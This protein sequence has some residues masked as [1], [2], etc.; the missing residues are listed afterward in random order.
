MMTHNYVHCRWLILLQA[1]N[2]LGV[3]LLQH[4]V[5]TVF[6]SFAVFI[7]L[8]LQLLCWSRFFVCSNF[9]RF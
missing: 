5:L 9:S 1:S 6:Y 2:T 4:N 8:F 7:I 3:V